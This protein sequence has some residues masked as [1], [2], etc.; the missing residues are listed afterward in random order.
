M[1]RLLATPGQ[2]NAT[3]SSLSAPWKTPHSQCEYPSWGRWVVW[4]HACG[5]SPSLYGSTSMPS[6]W[7]RMI[8]SCW[9]V[10]T[11]CRW[12]RIYES[13]LDQRRSFVVELREVVSHETI[14]MRMMLMLMILM[15]N[16]FYHSGLFIG[17]IFQPPGQTIF[18]SGG[19]NVTIIIIAMSITIYLCGIDVDYR[20]HIW[21]HRGRVH[22]GQQGSQGEKMKD[23]WVHGLINWLIAS[24]MA[25]LHFLHITFIVQSQQSSSPQP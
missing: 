22:P 15:M 3:V 7:I 6:W 23:G 10:M 2:R 1:P 5:R 14:M 11:W 19:E 17:R 25:A 18:N 21:S 8:S 16:L 13:T 12:W 20:L 24:S 9:E 4:W